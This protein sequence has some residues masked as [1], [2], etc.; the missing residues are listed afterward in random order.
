M[1]TEPRNLRPII[2]I[3]ICV[4]VIFGIYEIVSAFIAA[5][6]TGTLVVDASRSSAIISI[7]QANKQAKIIGTGSTHIRLAPGTYQLVATNNGSRTAVITKVSEKHSS[8]ISLN[9]SKTAVLPSPA[10]IN[11]QNLYFLIS[12]GLTQEQL[13]NLQIKIFQFR[14]HAHTVAIDASS[15]KTGLHNPNS[16]DPFTIN[17]NV[18]VDAVPYKATVNYTG[19]N[20]LRLYLYNPQTNA[21]MYDSAS[22]G[23]NDREL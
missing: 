20:D 18:T 21:L 23:F 22:S 5:S 13:S 7:S 15:I 6:N 1:D 10:S 11:F 12:Y 17:F 14:P 2:T 19:L 8:H 9:L 4:L 3:T 16:E